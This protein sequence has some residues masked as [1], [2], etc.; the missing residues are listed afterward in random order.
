MLW[1]P[2]LLVPRRAAHAARAPTNLNPQGR[3]DK[4]MTRNPTGDQAK[5]HTTWYDDARR[6][7]TLVTELKDLSLRAAL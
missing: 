5:C 1:K 7:R 4:T 3:A 6:F 2:G